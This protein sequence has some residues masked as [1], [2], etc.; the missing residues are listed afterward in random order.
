MTALLEN[1]EAL[2]QSYRKAPYFTGAG[3]PL[4]CHPCLCGPLWSTHR[5][6]ISIEVHLTEMH[7]HRGGGFDGGILYLKI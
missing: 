7:V 6:C 4:L 3:A 5:K 2:Q 1:L